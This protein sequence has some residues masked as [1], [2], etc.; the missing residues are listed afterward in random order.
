MKR[1]RL[2]WDEVR[3][4][5]WFYPSV[6]G[7]LALVAAVL[8]ARTDDALGGGQFVGWLDIARPAG[9]RAVLMTIAGSTITVAGVVFSIT[10]VVLNAAST[11]FGPRLVRNF[12]AHGGTQL[13]LATFI[14]TTVYALVGLATVGGAAEDAYEAPRVTLLGGLALALIS[15]GM[16][17]YFIHHVSLFMRAS[18]IIDDVARRLEHDLRS[19]LRRRAPGSSPGDEP[20][21]AAAG[22]PASVDATSSGY[23]QMVDHGRLT[24]IASERDAVIWSHHRAGHFLIEGERLVDVTPAPFDERTEEAIR[25][26]F[27]LGVER[28]PAQDPEFAI[29]QLVEIAMRALSP[30][31]ND[32]YTAINCVDR[33]ASALAVVAAHEPEPRVRRDR[34]GAIRVVTVAST[35]ASMVNAAFDQLRHVARD[36]LDVSIRLLD[37][38]ATLG[39]RDL[40]RAFRAALAAQVTAIG[41][42]CRGR[43]EVARDGAAF[44]ERLRAAERAVTGASKA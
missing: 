40:P 22:S 24:R 43:F 1:Y 39:A 20:D 41:E 23:V 6:F 44:D 4:S 37:A 25:R 10:M 27:A 19:S 42:G 36:H 16:L 33:I 3:S 29:R 31:I 12:M 32:P 14:G 2:R 28:S 7:A 9:A 13:V 34:G 35:Y 15:F 30:A 11:Q 21:P 18:H 5:Y 17:V 26:C 38:A 8:A